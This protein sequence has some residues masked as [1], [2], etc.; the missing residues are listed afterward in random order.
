MIRLR[1]PRAAAASNRDR[2]SCL[3]RSV[4][5]IAY[6]SKQS[7]GRLANDD[8]LVDLQILSIGL[9]LLERTWSRRLLLKFCIVN[10]FDD[11]RETFILMCGGSALLIASS[12]SSANST[13]P[14]L[15]SEAIS[16]DRAVLTQSC[17]L[18]S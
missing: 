6:L 7:R 16:G 15:R 1:H 12:I 9:A 10:S 18:V 17:S 8:C 11:V 4:E 13:S 3:K 5:I 14:I 2:I